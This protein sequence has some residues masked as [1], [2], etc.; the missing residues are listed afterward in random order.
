M[1]YIYKQTERGEYPL[2]TVGTYDSG[3]WDSESDHSKEEE[4]AERARYLNGGNT[5]TPLQKVA[6]D[7][8][9]ALEKAVYDLETV[10]GLGLDRIVL[11]MKDAIKK[12]K[13][14]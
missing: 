12:A 9:E 13:G 4:A 2:W 6:P 5:L 7:L 14:E 10:D 1:G 3:Q 8:L 11:N